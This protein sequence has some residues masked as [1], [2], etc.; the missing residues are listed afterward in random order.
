M[1]AR[2]SYLQAVGRMALARHLRR[3]PWMLAGTP[4]LGIDI[5][6]SDIDVICEVDDYSAF[7]EGLAGAFRNRRGF[8][9]WQWTG[10]ARCIVC[11]FEAEEWTFEIFG[12]T[13]PLACQVAVRHFEIE[14]RLLA[15]GD[16]RF[17]EAVRAA[18]RAGM[19]TEPAFAKLLGLA[20]D[21]YL[22]MLD[23]HEDTDAQLDRRLADAGF[24]PDMREYWQ[25]AKNP[26]R[27][28]H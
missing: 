24:C 7:A 27:H 13:A 6:G 5:S 17:A 18:K 8:R 19:K 28:N 16:R 20:D 14:K 21:P 11:R 1:G 3:W 4:P 10:E 23:I 12:S 25:I 2:I 9:I 22:A 26:P 15:R